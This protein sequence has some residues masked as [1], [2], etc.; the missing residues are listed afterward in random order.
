[1]SAEKDNNV[2]FEG[3]KELRETVEKKFSDS[4]EA[5]EKISKIEKDLGDI[6]EKHQKALEQEIAHKKAMETNIADLKEKYETLYKQKN[7]IGVGSSAKDAEN[8]LYAKY[9]G[10]MDAYLRKGKAP[11]MDILD[12]IAKNIIS[13]TMATKED[14]EIA[15]QK[16]LVTGSNP[17]GGFLIFPDRRTDLQVNRIFETTPMRSL[18]GIITTTSNEVEVIVNDDEFTSGGWVGEVQTRGDTANGQFGQLM[19]ATHEQFAQPKVTQKMLDDSSINI[20]SLIGQ[21]VDA[22]LTRTENTAFVVGDGAAKPKGFLDFAAWDVAGTYERNKIEQVNSGAAGVVKAD[23]LISLQ[24]ALIQDY[25]ANANWMMK[26]ATWGDVLKLKD[27]NGNYLLNIEM[28]PEGAGLMLLG[29]RVWFA[30]DMPVV[31]NDSLSIAY[32]DFGVGYTI[33]DR[34]GIRVLRDPFT[35]KPF[36]KFYTTKRVGGTVTNFESIKIQKLAA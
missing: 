23:G 31:A 12:D 21:Q 4:G 32:G 5:K 36:I 24:N 34:L 10:E 35:D 29:K 13:K 22:I 28:L 8:E 11:S 14:H 18:G 33:V 1:M 9:S 27:G 15:H 17:E 7:R 20:E 26:R 25:D 19:I 16:S 6:H 30:N 2:L 3:L